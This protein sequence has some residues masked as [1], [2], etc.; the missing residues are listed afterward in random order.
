MPVHFIQH[1]ANCIYVYYK[2]HLENGGQF[3]HR[4]WDTLVFAKVRAALGGNVRA[5]FSGSAPLAREV[6]EFIQIVLG[7]PFFEG[8]GLT[9]TTC[10]GSL[11]PGNILTGN[12]VGMPTPGAQMRLQDV[13]DMNYTN[14]DVPRPRALDADGWFHTGDIGA[15]NADGMLSII[16]RKKNIFK[17]AQGEYVAPQVFVYGD[18]LQSFLVGVVVP[19]P[20]AAKKW[21]EENGKADVSLAELCANDVEFKAV[22]AKDMLEKAKANKLFGFEMVKKMH[23]QAEAF[24]VEQDLVTPTF[25]LKRPQLQQHFQKQIYA[26]F[27]AAAVLESGGTTARL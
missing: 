17:L 4:L 2:Y 27:G 12:N 5:V 13:P 14:D 18:S 10:S 11:L 1:V 15:W 16:D 24:T 8:Y 6:K 23:L 3:T 26:M 21:Q 22:V 7:C 19:D 25:K 9:E 20:D